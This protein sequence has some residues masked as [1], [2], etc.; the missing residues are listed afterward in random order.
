MRTAEQA[1]TGALDG[2]TL[3]W[4]DE[5]N[6]ATNAVGYG[7][8]AWTTGRENPCDAIKRGYVWGR[9]NRR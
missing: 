9:D 5:I 8:G 7:I 4:I 6:G 2:L 1:V 3:G